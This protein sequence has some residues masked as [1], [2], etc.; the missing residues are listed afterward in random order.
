M[1]GKCTRQ[2]IFFSKITENYFRK[3]VTIVVREENDRLYQAQVNRRQFEKI[4]FADKNL[5][6]CYVLL[7][8]GSIR[9]SVRRI[10]LKSL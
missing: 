7:E 9:K 1:E 8:E 3:G 5:Q 2:G 6:I 10:G 4:P